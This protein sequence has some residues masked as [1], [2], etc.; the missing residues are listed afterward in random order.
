MRLHLDRLFRQNDTGRVH[1]ARAVHR[2]SHVRDTR[3]YI[4]ILP[5][6]HTLVSWSR[7]GDR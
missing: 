3:G 2:H 7:F 1:L 5:R 6:A 4:K